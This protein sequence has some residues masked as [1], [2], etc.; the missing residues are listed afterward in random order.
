M[1]FTLNLKVQLLEKLR[2]CPENVGLR[3]AVVLKQL[4]ERVIK[5][6][7][8]AILQVRSFSIVK[9]ILGCLEFIYSK[10]KGA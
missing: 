3:C 9:S 5:I 7:K 1:L 10:N 2:P 4:L 8:K 6:S